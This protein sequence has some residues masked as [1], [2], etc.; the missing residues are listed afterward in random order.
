MKKKTSVIKALIVCLLLAM[1]SIGCNGTCVGCGN[2]TFWDFQ[3][4]FNYAYIQLPTGEV[5]EGKLQEW[6]DYE[7]EQLQVKINGITYLTSTF[8]CTLI[9]DPTK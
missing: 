7:G 2:K 4:T 6:N 8:N 3:Y 5:I 9:Y 1:F